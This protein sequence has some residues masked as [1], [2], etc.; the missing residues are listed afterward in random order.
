LGVSKSRTHE[1]F[2]LEFHM[3]AKRQLSVT[4]LH[5]HANFTGLR[6][7]RWFCFSGG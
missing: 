1:C 4:R 5:D 3:D 2:F 7:H 6:G